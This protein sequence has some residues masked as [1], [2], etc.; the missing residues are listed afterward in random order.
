MSEVQMDNK[1]QKRS[2]GWVYVLVLV[3]ALA[4]LGFGVYLAGTTRGYSVLAAGCASVVGVLI[5]WPI[6]AQLTAFHSASC[7]QAE[8]ALT[9]INERFEQFSVMLNLISEQQL[10]S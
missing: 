3:L 8:R 9:S 2:F 4:V 10:L 6:A 1:S 7:D 5:A